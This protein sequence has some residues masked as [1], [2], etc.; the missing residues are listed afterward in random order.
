MRLRLLLIP[1]L[2]GA[3]LRA[4][5]PAAKEPYKVGGSVSRPVIVYQVEPEYTQDALKAHR[6]GT[7][8]IQLVVTRDGEPSEL[9]ELTQPLGYGL[10]E[11]AIEAVQQW[12]FRPGEKSG[13]PVAVMVQVQVNFRPP[14]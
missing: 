12:R 10:D 4:Q 13:Q 6:G 5:P 1:V 8:L 9:Q 2:L 11:K 7:A 3:T 14:R